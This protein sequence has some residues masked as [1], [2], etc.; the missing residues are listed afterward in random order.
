MI[1]NIIRFNKGLNKCMDDYCLELIKN[2]LVDIN[3]E[4]IY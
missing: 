3:V 1:D 4:N 2:R